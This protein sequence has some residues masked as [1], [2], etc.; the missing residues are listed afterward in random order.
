MSLSQSVFDQGRAV[1][2]KLSILVTLATVGF[3]PPTIAVAKASYG[4]CRAKVMKDPRFLDGRARAG[5]GKIC[6]AAIRRCMQNN[7]KID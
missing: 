3:I 7:G 1:M 4:D 6:G 2:R 5:C